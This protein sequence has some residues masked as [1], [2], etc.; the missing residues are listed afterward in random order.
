MLNRVSLNHLSGPARIGALV[1]LVLPL[2]L[3][4]FLAY[5]GFAI[6]KI[7]A[8][9]ASSASRYPVGPV[10]GV[11]AFTLWLLV[12]FGVP[13]LCGGLLGAGVHRMRIR[14]SGA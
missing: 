2:L 8:N 14:K 9:W 11:I 3:A 6:A 7:S 10:V 12:V 1:G 4:P 13:A 5:A